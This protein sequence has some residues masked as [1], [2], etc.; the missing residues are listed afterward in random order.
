MLARLLLFH[1]APS[2]TLAT[3]CFSH[4]MYI[5][6]QCVMGDCKEIALFNRSA[7]AGTEQPLKVI[8]RLPLG[9]LMKLIEFLE[10]FHS[11][12]LKIS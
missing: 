4:L 8:K 1:C 6:S 3:V 7:C 12:S 9:V 10:L 11:E 5:S 2:P